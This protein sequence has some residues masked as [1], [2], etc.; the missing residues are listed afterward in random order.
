MS[1]STGRFGFIAGRKWMTAASYRQFSRGSIQRESMA[2]SAGHP[3][4]G[5]RLR[6]VEIVRDFDVD[7]QR[8]DGLAPLQLDDDLVGIEHYMSAPPRR[9]FPRAAWPA[10]RTGRAVRAHAPAE[11]AAVPGRRGRMHCGRETAA[12]NS[13][14]CS[15]PS[16]QPVH[17]ALAL[18]RHHHRDLLAHQAARGVDIGAGRRAFGIVE[19][20][21]SADV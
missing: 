2:L 8:R 1:G 4:L 5:Q 13:C 9:E 18:R 6:L 14:S 17:E 7:L 19:R 15:S 20:H 11:S 3:P 21:G 10:G 16:Q 12:A